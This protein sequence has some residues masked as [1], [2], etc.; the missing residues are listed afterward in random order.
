MLLLPTK[1]QWEG[2][3]LPSKLGAVSAYVGLPLAVI[4]LVIG[5]ISLIPG[6]P[7][8][9]DELAKKILEKQNLYEQTVAEQREAIETLRVTIDELQ[10]ESTDKVKSDELKASGK[11]EIAK[12]IELIENWYHV[13]KE[14]VMW[15]FS[16]AGITFFAG[17]SGFIKLFKKDPA[18]ELTQKLVDKIPS[19]KIMVEKDEEI[20]KL[21]ARLPVKNSKEYEYQ[22]A[23]SF[24]GEDR[25]IAKELAQK[26]KDKGLSVFFDEYEQASLWGKNLYDHL[27]S[28]YRDKA[29][30]CIILISKFYAEKLWTRHELKQAQ[31][32]AFTENKEYILP[33]RIDDTEISGISNTTAYL[34][35]RN[36]SIQEVV[37]LV[38][39]KLESEI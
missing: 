23:L 31:E 37:Q 35:M 6:E 9:T 38:I 24:A 18:Y 22:I 34:D 29:R 30:F 13:N 19:P 27:Q 39:K 33:L 10:W 12:V 2:W 17:I 11:G 15:V 28:V 5:L 14:W 4:G 20:Q 16:G 25:A 32:R 21:R 26:S 1:K 3:S 7:I 8:N 36:I